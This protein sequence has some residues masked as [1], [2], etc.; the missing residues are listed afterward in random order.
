MTKPPRFAESML[1]AVLT[2]HVELCEAMLGDLAEGWSTRVSIEGARWADRWYW[3]QTVRSLPSLLALGIR[4]VGLR[5]LMA[6]TAIAIVA[7]LLMLILQYA[8]LV[9]GTAAMSGRS[10]IAIALAI[11]AWC[12]GAAML[13]GFVIGRLSA[14]HAAVRVGV[15]CIAVLVLHV[16]SPNLIQPA[17]PTW[18]YWIT[19]APLSAIAAFVG[20]AYG[21]HKR[22]GVSA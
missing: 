9:I 22:R 6:I 12:L 1:R 14:R 7:R 8:A 18:L 16:V 2:E 11:V 4:N 3:S 17:M 5:E 20:A 15:L 19:T 21:H 10:S 13:T